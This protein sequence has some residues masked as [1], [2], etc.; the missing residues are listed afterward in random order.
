ML[1]LQAIDFDEACN[2][3][4]RFHRHHKP[5][6]GHK[7]SV[8]CNDGVKV[9]GVAMVGRPVARMTDDGETLEVNRVATDGT[10]NACSFL[11]GACRRAAFSLGYRRLITYTLPS[12]G[13]VSLKAAGW[14]LIGERGGGKWSRVSR[15][16]LDVHPIGVKLLWECYP[17]TPPND[18]GRK[19]RC[20]SSE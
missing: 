16:R 20:E 2:F 6:V 12:E 13:G 7:F 4:R 19:N 1:V 5:P 11:Y 18:A 9:V 14:K 17:Q 10:K 3:V 15:T 8:A